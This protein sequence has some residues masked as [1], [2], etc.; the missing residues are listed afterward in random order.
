MAIAHVSVHRPIATTMVYL[1]IITLGMISFRFLPVDLLPPIEFPQLNIRVNYGNVGPEEMELIVT[2]RIENA[3]SGVPN[4]E[5]TFSASSEGRSNVQLRFAQGTNLDEAA[6]DVRAAL[7][8]VRED[9]PDDIEPPEIRKFDPDQQP[10]VILGARSTRP[11]DQLTEILENDLMRRFQQ[12]PGV[13]AI[14]V[15]GGVYREVQVDLIRD[16]LV[17]TEL[18]ANDVVAAIGRENVNLPGGNVRDGLR[19]LYVRSLGEY[20]T[21]DQVAN[22]VVAVVDGN[23]VRVKD[24]AEVRMG[25]RDLGRY[26]EIQDLPTIRMG[27]RKQSGANTVEVS[28][29]IRQ[30]MAEING[31]RSDLELQVIR[32]QAD[33]IQDSIDNVRNSAIWGGI[34]SVIILMAFL[35][36][37]SATLIIAIAI[38]ISIVATFG[39]VYFAGLTLN[40]MSF[41]GIAL[42]VGMIVDNSIVVLE[43]IVRQR[44]RGEARQAAALVGARQVTGAIIASTLT[45]CVIFLPVVFMQNV[46]AMLFT[47]LAMVVVFALLCSLF[48]ALTLVPM[49]S[50]RFLT[51]RPEADEANRAG[52]LAALERWYARTVDHVLDRRGTVVAASAGLVIV[53]VLLLPLIPF[54]LAPETDGEQIEVSMRMDDG[55]NIAVMYEYVQLL[56]TAVQEVVSPEDVV[57]VTNDVRNNRASVQL[58]LVGPDERSARSQEIADRIRA[59]VANTIPGADIN[60]SAESGL[61]ILRRLFRSGGGGEGGESLQLQLRGYDLDVA[62]DITR[63]IV[64]RIEAIP[65]IEDVDASNRERRPEQRIVFD[66][67]RIAELGIGVQDIATAIQTSIGGRRAGVFRVGGEEIDITVRLRPEDRFSVLDLDNITVRTA[68]GILPVSALIEQE[69]GRGPVDVYRIDGQRVS[70][71]TANLESGVALGE[72]V[73]RIQRA[74][75]DLPL[76]DGFSLSFGGEYEE[77]QRAQ[78]DFLLAIITAFALIYM[79]MAAQFERFID[80][81]IVMVSVPV[82]IVGVVPA[83]LLTGTTFNLQSFMGLIMLVGIVVNNAIVLVDY[84]NLLRREKGMPVRAAVVEAGRLRLRPILMTTGTTVLGLLPLA[85]AIGAGAELQAALARVVI[86]GL[87]ASTLITLVLIPVIY[88]TVAE[89]FERRAARAAARARIGTEPLAH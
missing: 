82:A 19:D 43:N 69:S 47:E 50:S 13:G 54:E 87:M 37:G 86:G 59:H 36:N 24:V 60:V 17:A 28:R 5:Q 85:F 58:T 23:P 1:I 57:F 40:Q 39:L 76:P 80:P 9:L 44:Q 56:D 4:L 3:V 48:I 70:F 26:V 6:N 62:E 22:T 78:R 49:L 46:T 71:I 81:L 74:L 61:W 18:T 55:T 11:L 63:E 79:V 16:R 15:W 73:G 65:G 52:R 25:Y 64:N 88:V 68:E 30:E 27:I 45:T 14:E 38:P 8:R 83:M 84:I 89:R 67:R 2:E 53:A 33:F 42:G 31:L 10:I 12:I 32:D 21:V 20:T 7:D 29:R 72:A 41:G 34:L 66:R 35:R 75:A 77:Q 51:V